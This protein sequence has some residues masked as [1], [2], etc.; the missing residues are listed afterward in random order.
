M[1]DAIMTP[2]DAPSQNALAIQTEITDIVAARDAALKTMAAAIKDMNAALKMAE[3]ATGFAKKA[4]H[5]RACL[6]YTPDSY[7]T[8]QPLFQAAINADEAL[9]D[10]RNNLDTG[11]WNHLLTHSGMSSMMD[12]T[13]KKEFRE[14]LKNAIPATEENIRATFET[15]YA[16]SGDIFVRGMANAFTKLD[17]RFRSNDAFKVGKVIVLKNAFCKY[18]GSF[19]YGET[20]DTIIDIERIFAKLENMEP[21]PHGLMQAIEKSR[22]GG[23]GPKQSVVESRYFRIR[24]WKNGNAHLWFQRNDLVEKVNKVLADYYGE[25]LPDAAEKEDRPEDFKVESTAVSKDLQ[26]YATPKKVCERVLHFTNIR[27]GARVLE[28][29]AGEGNLATEILSTNPDITLDVV[30]V[31]PG[32]AQKLKM[33]KGIS[34]V[35]TTNFLEY[36]SPDL[37]DHIIMNPPFSGTHWMAHI[38]H[39]YDLLTPGGY[40]HAILP[41]SAQDGGTAKHK[42]FHAWIEATQNAY[43]SPWFEL[44]AGSFKSSGTNINTVILTLHKSLRA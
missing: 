4:H 14:N 37:Y 5:G 36:S 17:R 13:A 21:D 31:H 32:R 8:C 35:H 33:I 23:Y 2:Y 39:A 28:P 18:S 9:E 26:F 43:H 24:G 19:E 27:K 38:L 22:T 34:R 3:N 6:L 10:Y 30:E 12:A 29:S 44:P 42:K 41:S 11:I 25:V 15:L 20:R 40:L 1:N 7:N 16:N